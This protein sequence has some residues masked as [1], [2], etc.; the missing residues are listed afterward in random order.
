MKRLQMLLVAVA[1]VAS[2][3]VMT[4]VAYATSGQ[5]NKCLDPSDP[6]S[7]EASIKVRGTGTITT[8]DGRPLC[9]DGKMTFASYNVPDS[10]DKKGWNKTAIPQTLYADT[11][12]TFPAG[13]SDYSMTLNVDT[14]DACKHTQLDFYVAPSYQKID[15]LTA[16]DGRNVIGVLFAGKGECE[17]KKPVVEIKKLVNG[18]DSAVVTVGQ[19]FTYTVA[20][21]NTGQVDLVNAVVTDPAPAGVTMLAA[22][23][24]MI[25]NNT[26]T[27]KIP[28]LKVGETVTIS[29]TAKV[30]EYKSGNMVNTACINAAEINQGTPDKDDA[31]D[32]ATVTVS[33]PVTPVTPEVPS[34]LPS[35][36]VGDVVGISAAVAVLAGAIYQFVLRRRALGK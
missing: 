15:T 22:T 1:T 7:Y 16:D 20:V 29:I 33:T 11:E 26:L 34:T 24:G 21:T 12:F 10:W 31:C 3:A 13:K 19:S 23:P 18:V 36:G 9:S 30:P 35:T 17:E 14:P 25:T 28:S 6:R 32:T 27:Y 8:A 4:P 5:Q 2:L